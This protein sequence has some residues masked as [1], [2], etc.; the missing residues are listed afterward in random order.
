MRPALASPVALATSWTRSGTRQLAPL[1]RLLVSPCGLFACPSHDARVG[2]EL[3]SRQKA[4]ARGRR[5]PVQHLERRHRRRARFGV[6]PQ[7]NANLSQTRTAFGPPAHSAASAGARQS[8][9]ARPGGHK[10]ASHRLRAH[11]EPTALRTVGHCGR[12][13][14]FAPGRRPACTL[15]AIL[16][17]PRPMRGSVCTDPAAHARHGAAWSARSRTGAAHPKCPRPKLRVGTRKRPPHTHPAAALLPISRPQCTRGGATQPSQRTASEC[18]LLR[19]GVGGSAPNA[20]TPL[21]RRGTPRAACPTTRPPRH[22]NITPAH[23]ARQEI[24]RRACITLRAARGRGRRRFC[25]RA[26]A[27]WLASPRSRGLRTHAPPSSRASSAAGFRRP[28]TPRSR[29]R[30]ARRSP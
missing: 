25:A 12:S 29:R 7:P 21:D 30:A 19:T 13:S 26:L 22:V 3:R 20:S 10:F 16:N 28:R 8:P 23:M 18:R 1:G 15:C 17:R 6:S 5:H 2:L 11:Q 14:S 27:L 24:C 4:E 9:A